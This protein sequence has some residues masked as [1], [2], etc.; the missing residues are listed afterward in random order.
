MFNKQ[1]WL[2]FFIGAQNFDFTIVGRPVDDDVTWIKYKTLDPTKP[3]A[4]YVY[5]VSQD[6]SLQA[7]AAFGEKATKTNPVSILCR[8]INPLWIPIQINAIWL[9][10]YHNIN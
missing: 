2:S 9:V 8:L 4:V 7:F 5:E 6:D 1:L 10:L 3:F